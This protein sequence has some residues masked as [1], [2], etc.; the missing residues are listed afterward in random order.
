MQRL[1]CNKISIAFEDLGRG[2]PLVLIMG[3]SARGAFWEDHLKEYVK[4]FRCIVVDNRGA[5]DSD[6]PDGPYTTRTMAE[7]IAELINQL[8]LPKVHVAGISMGGA[9]AQELA[10]HHPSLVQSLTLISTWAKL[11]PYAIQVFDHLKDMRKTATPAEFMKLLQLW[12]FAPPYYQSAE[13]RHSMDEGCQTA[14]ENYMVL[15]AFCAQADA[16]MSHDSVEQV[17]NIKVPTLITVGDL[18]VFTPIE[19]SRQL[20]ELIPDSTLCEFEGAGHAHHWEDLQS[21]NARTIE[22]MLAH[23]IQTGAR[24]MPNTK[25]IQEP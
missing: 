15:H 3:L 18:D 6:K 21:F 9:I 13:N 4:H 24:Q 17:A 7:D 19:F 20:H 16:C 11:S 2:D 1:K 5:G 23:A 12:I 14:H 10:I 25:T 22:F 8:E